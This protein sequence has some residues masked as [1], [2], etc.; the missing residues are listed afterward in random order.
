M[1]H[2]QYRYNVEACKYEPWYLKGKELRN[3]V[4][5]F[6]ALSLTIAAIG[7]TL[8][9]QQVGS[10]DEIVLE[11]KNVVLKTEWRIL[12]DRI[13]D[14]YTHLNELIEKD[15]HNYRVILDSSP[16]SSHIREAGIGGSEKFDRRELKNFPLIL[17]SYATLENLSHQ[18]DVEVQSF[19]EL[20]KMVNERIEMWAS[21]PAIQPISNKQLDRLH[22]TYGARLHPIFHVYLD[23]KGL[24]FAASQGTPVYATG[25]GRITMAYFS[26]SYGN[27]IYLDHGH[28]YE[29]RYAH[30]SGF[31]IKSGERVKRGQIIGY[32]GSTGNSVS[33]HLHYEVLYKGQHTNPINFFQR[34]LNNKEYEK[35][36]EIGSQQNHP[37]D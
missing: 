20:N 4:F 18:L 19:E 35:L 12:E 7:C 13:A 29:T 5:I 24:D 16:L 34:D 8:Y 22:M 33:A 2:I 32:V 31:A 37:L 26:G 36:I 21:R 6:M 30:L 9:I 1:A 17:Q 14:S 10:F 23:H 15:D 11:Q 27:V 25:D 3:K 28:H